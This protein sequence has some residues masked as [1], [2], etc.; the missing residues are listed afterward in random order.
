LDGIHEDVISQIYNYEESLLLG[1]LGPTASFW[2][3][4]LQMVQI[5]LDFTRSIKQGNWKL[6]LQSTENMVRRQPGKFNKIATDQAIEQTINREQKCAGGIIGYCTSES[7]V[8]RWVLTSHIAAKIQAKMENVLGISETNTITK[9]LS[10][11]RILFDEECVNRAYDL[12]QDWG[13]PFEENYSLV[14]I[15]SGVECGTDIESDMIGAE[16]KGKDAL[17]D[18]IQD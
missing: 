14:N 17:R 15:S 6:H 4:F 8:Q 3:S 16:K 12:I 10:K 11:K 5:L 9:D 7:T 1:S 13:T 2:S 18:F